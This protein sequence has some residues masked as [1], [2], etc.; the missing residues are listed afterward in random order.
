MI[1]T[2]RSYLLGV[3]KA[4]MSESRKNPIEGFSITPVLGITPLT[5]HFETKGVLNIVEFAKE[6][7]RQGFVLA[8]AADPLGLRNEATMVK[9]PHVCRTK[10]CG[11]F[12]WRCKERKTHRDPRD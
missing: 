7:H 6:L 9:Q 2:S 5:V 4:V 11:F 12:S 3:L 8:S 1:A 10:S